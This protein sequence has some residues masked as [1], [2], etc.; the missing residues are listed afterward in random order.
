MSKFLGP[1]HFW[2][3]RK[4]QFQESLIDALISYAVQEGW[5]DEDLTR[6]SC[7]DRR[8]LDEIID[9][10]NIHG[11][12]QARIQDAE[13][14]YAALVLH[15]VGSDETRL[16]ALKQAAVAF[17]STQN[18]SASTAPEAFHRLDDL[19]LDACRAIR[20]TA[21]PKAAMMP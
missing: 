7:Q 9:E 2:L 15:L 4:I 10:T 18:L 16:S 8:Q 13:K 5:N 19:L 11:W 12:L 14:R 17:G 21:F 3:Y 6:Y 20:S 1:V